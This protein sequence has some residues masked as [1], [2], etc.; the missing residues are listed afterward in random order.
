MPHIHTLSHVPFEG[1]GHIADW[2]AVRGHRISH[3]RLFDGD[4]I[5]PSADYDWLLVMG[6]P[7]GV[8]DTERFPWLIDEADA[9]R[10]AV[11]AGKTVLGVCLGAQLIAHAL[12]ARVAPHAHKEIGWFPVTRL[13]A[14]EARFSHMP[15][16]LPVLHWHGDRFDLP[17][18][19]QHLFRSDAC[20]PQGFSID[21]R[22]FGF[23]F[24]FETT[25]ESLA[26][27]VE[28]CREE[29]QEGPFVQ[30]EAEILAQNAHFSAMH[31]VL[32][33]FLDELADR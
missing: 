5:A 10:E 3:A 22:V 21:E 11:A 23:Q 24:H 4:A 27:L 32:D 17:Q 15:A 14:A 13:P 31:R 20:E 6:G 29:L 33:R 8:H 18:R 28:N 30:P 19:A 25:P 16:S 7:M 1:P 26:A 12:G 2:A 9:I